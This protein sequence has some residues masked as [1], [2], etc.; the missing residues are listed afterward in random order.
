MAANMMKRSR[1][2]EFET[3]ESSYASPS[4]PTSKAQR[5]SGR[6]AAEGSNPLLCT[7]PPTC[8]PPHNKPAV[9]A[10]SQ[11]LESHYAKYHAFVCEDEY[12]GAVF[13]GSRLLELVRSCCG[14]SWSRLPTISV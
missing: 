6:A 4:S 9:L 8:H 1:T 12:C 11:Q 3:A 7:L 10:D 5:L 2:D 13:P 14:L